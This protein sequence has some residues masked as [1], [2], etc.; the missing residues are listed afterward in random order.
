VAQTDS[1]LA[2]LQQQQQILENNSQQT[3]MSL[4]KTFD[5]KAADG[6]TIDI[7]SVGYGT[8]ASGT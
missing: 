8:W 6:K 1:S 3:I 5:L 7:P 2:L 4:P